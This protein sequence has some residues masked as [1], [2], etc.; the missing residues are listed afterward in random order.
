MC[1]LWNSA[2]VRTSRMRGASWSR[3][4]R[5]VDASMRRAVEGAVLMVFLRTWSGSLLWLDVVT[6]GV[7]ASGPGAALGALAAWVRSGEGGDGLPGGVAGDQQEQPGERGLELAG[8][9]P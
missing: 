2:G 3:R 5:S 4:S 9:D 8:V 1:P 6:R 7:R